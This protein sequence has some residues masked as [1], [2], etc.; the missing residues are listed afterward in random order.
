MPQPIKNGNGLNLRGDDADSTYV[1]NYL[2]GRTCD[3]TLTGGSATNGGQVNNHL[4]SGRGDDTLTGGSA[5]NGGSAYNDLSSGKGNDA[6]TGGS[7]TNGGY[8]E[9]YL[10]GGTGDNTLIG[11]TATNGGYV[12]NYLSGGTG[13]NTLTG[14]SATNGGSVSNTF[15]LDRLDIGD[16]VTGGGSGTDNGLFANGTTAADNLVI[17]ATGWT[18]NGTA[19]AISGIQIFGYS[20]D[21]G[22][23]LIDANQSGF[24]GSHLDGAFGNDTLIGSSGDDYLGGGWDQMTDTFVFNLNSGND[25]I[26]DFSAGSDIDHDIIDLSAYGF[27]SLEEVRAQTQDYDWYSVIDL[28]ASNSVTLY[29]VSSSALMS[30]NFIFA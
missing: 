20:A 13:D 29:N 7:A 8:V 6:L 10:S 5:T 1:E 14:G 9:N 21:D 12:Y 19:L 22:N 23:D 4:S 27:T 28:D 17:S 30:D 11:G 18:L 2:S 26:V 15:Y 24:T 3:D 25:N 16:Q